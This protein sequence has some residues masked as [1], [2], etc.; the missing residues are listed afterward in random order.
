MTSEHEEFR[1]EGWSWRH[2]PPTGPRRD[3]PVGHHGPAPARSTPS[4]LRRFARWWGREDP[5][6]RAWHLIALGIVIVLSTLTGWLERS[7]GAEQ[8]TPVDAEVTEQTEQFAS[9]D[10]EVAGG[11]EQLTAAA[12]GVVS[13]IYRLA[14]GPAAPQTEPGLRALWDWP[15]AGERTVVRP[16]DPPDQPWLPGHRGVDLAG[17]AG[18]PVLAV[19]D[20][21]VTFSGTIAGVGIVSVTHADGVRSTY[22]PVDEAVPAGSRVARGDALGVLGEAGNHCPP[23]NCLHLG[24]LRGEDY[25]DPLLFLEPW[26]VSLLPSAG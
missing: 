24:A 25:L 10:R 26:E 20:G 7:A 23:Q 22:Q 21:T 4:R 2:Q 15:L 3:D 19:T 14:P 18:A 13:A 11:T 16:F 17:A 12:A 5:R 6:F 9:G 8:L 1:P